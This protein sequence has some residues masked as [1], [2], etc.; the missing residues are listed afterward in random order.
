MAKRKNKKSRQFS[1]VVCVLLMLAA[2]FF[3]AAP[4]MNLPF[5]VPTWQELF[6]QS[7][8]S[9]SEAERQPLSVHFLDVGQGDSI[10]IKSGDE[11]MLIDAGEKENGEKIVSY[12]KEHGVKKLKYAVCTHP[13]ADHIGGMAA[14][15]EG[16]PAETV[17]MAKVPDGL[18]PTT[19]AYKR[20]LSAIASSEAKASY[21]KAGQELT[22]GKAVFQVLGPVK[23]YEDLNNMSLVLRLTYGENSFLFTGDEESKAEKDLLKKNAEL[24]ADVLKC[25]HHGSRTSTSADFLKAVSPKWA[26]ASCGENNDYGH[27]HQETVK[28]L[29]N[30]GVNFLRTDQSGTVVIGSDGKKLYASMEKEAA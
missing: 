4:K 29:L 10:L 22:L 25:G 9:L 13:H 15:L 21:A 27:P 18:L 5:H 12:L 8:V 23:T 26:V 16:I 24:K 20:L 11:A 1:V 19:S 14:V 6:G 17:L 28:R 2:A 7:A 30:F 3:T